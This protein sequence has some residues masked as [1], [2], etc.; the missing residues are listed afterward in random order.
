MLAQCPRPQPSLRAHHNYH[1]PAI[2]F[3]GVQSRASRLLS[4]ITAWL[5]MRPYEAGLTL[6][7]PRT[8]TSH[9]PPDEIHQETAMILLTATP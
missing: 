9:R 3:P 1:L 2:P 5:A 8:L 6:R 4:Y 7:R